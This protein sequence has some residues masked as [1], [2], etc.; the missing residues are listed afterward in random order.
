MNDFFQDQTFLDDGSAVPEIDPYS[1]N[2]I[3]SSLTVTPEEVKLTLEALPV[4]KAT[5]PDGLS[6]RMLKEISKEICFP[7]AAFF[8]HSFSSG[9][10]PDAFK[11]L[12]VCPVPEGGNP[13]SVANYRPISLLSNLDKTLEHLVFKNLYNHFR[14]NNIITSFQSGFIPGDSTVNQLTYLYN[15]II[16]FV[17]HWKRSSSRFFATLPRHLIGFGMRV[18][19]INYVPQGFRVIFSNCLLVI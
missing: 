13:A 17:K 2:E 1:V 12:H 3:F 15:T 7:L 6:N 8:N 11:E 16:L 4:G 9:E 5:G 10:V 19:F 18:L 14:N